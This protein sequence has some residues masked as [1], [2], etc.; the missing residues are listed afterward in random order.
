MTDRTE[1]PTDDSHFGTCEEMI[2]RYRDLQEK[3]TAAKALAERRKVA[4]QRVMVE[5]SI[6]RVSPPETKHTL[7]KKVDSIW[8]FIEKFFEEEDA[9]LS[10][11]SEQE[12]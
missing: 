10:A 8:E 6:K 9:A 1:T 2:A 12:K 7:Q 11:K 4:L 5:V 3:L